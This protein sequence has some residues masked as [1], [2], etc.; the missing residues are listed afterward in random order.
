MINLLTKKKLFRLNKTHVL[1]VLFLISINSFSQFLNSSFEDNTTNIA[2][3]TPNTNNSIWSDQNLTEII[4]NN[5]KNNVP[6]IDQPYVSNRLNE[7]GLPYLAKS[8]NSEKT[9]K[10][11]ITNIAMVDTDNDGVDDV[12]DIDDD[13][14]GILDVN[15]CP[16]TEKIIYTYTGTDQ[17]YTVPSNATSVTAKIWGAGGRG[18][19]R[20]G[21]GVGAA[22]GYTEFTIS[23]NDITNNTLILTVGEGGNSSTGSPTYGNGGAGSSA[24]FNRA[25]RNFGA[26]GGMS[27]ISYTTL[28]TPSS[29]TQADLLAIAGGGGSMPAYSNANTHAGEGGG[30][31]GGDAT[32]NLATLNGL[33]G[34]QTAGGASTNGNAGSFLQGGNSRVNGAAGGGGYYGGGGGSFLNNH[35]G[36]GGG[37]SS[38]ITSLATAY[39]TIRG[40][41]QLPPMSGDS[42][43]IS[44]VGTGGSTSAQNGG[45]GLIV[46][47]ITLE[48]DEDGDGIINSFD[49]DSDN[50]GIPDNLE[51]QSTV[52][53]IVPSGNDIDKDGLDDTYDA[54]LSGSEN[55]LGITPV[56]TDD[57]ANIGADTLP[58][59]LD[60]DADGDG[61]FD[62]IESGTVL[63]NDGNGVSTGTFGI[64]G[65]NDLAETGNTDLGYTD[66]NGSFDNTQTDNFTDIDEDVLTFGDVDYRD[67]SDD[68]IAMITQVYQF[69]DERW[70]E[71]TNINKTKSIAANL[72][73]IQLYVDRTGTQ[74]TAPNAFYTFPNILAAGKSILLKS[75]NNT[76]TN[77]DNSD[78][79]RVITNDVITNFAG[80]NDMV[81]LSSANDDSSYQNRYDIIEAF[82]DKTSHVRIDETLI[83]NKDYDAAEWVVFIDDAILP[84]QTV[85][86]TAITGV[87]RHPQDPLISEIT[88]SNTAANT[89]LGLHNIDITT[90][91]S[92][93]NTWTN[94]YPDRSRSVVIDQDFEHT[95]NRLSARK[96]KVNA[97]QELTVT[98]QLLVVTN[99]ITL[100]GDIRLAGT[101]A[102]LVQTHTTGTK[103]SGNGSLLVDQNSEIPS[104]YRYGY[105]SSPVNSSGTTYTVEDV[106]KDGT[107]PT[108]PKDITFVS[109]FDGSFT[110]TGIS[111]ADYWIYTYAPAS[112]GRANWVQQFK[113]GVINRA[114]GYIFKG[115]GRAQNYTFIGTPNDGGF[116]TALPIG[117]GDDYLVGNPFP[118]AMNARK[119]IEDNLATTTGT[120]YLWEH[121]ESANGEGN[122][123]DGHVFGGY[124]GG[125]ATI[126]LGGTAAASSNV[127]DNN[128][129]GTSG[130]GDASYS[131]TSPLPYIAIG[132]G[133]FIE[134]DETTGGIVNFNNSQRAY[135]TEGPESVFFKANKKT[136]TTTT[137]LLPLIKLGFEYKNTDE[138]NIHHQI[139]VTFQETNSFAFNK[140]YDSEVYETG[141]TDMYWKFP[142][143]DK[144]YV[145]AGVQEISNELE[146]PLEVIVDYS[147]QVNIMVDETENV[148]RDIYI[149]DK[150]TGTSYNVTDEKIT[151]TL[152]KGIYTDRFVLAFSESNVLG[153][154]D[155]DVLSAFTNIYADNENHQIVISKN[156]EVEINKVE[157]FDILGKKV[158]TWKIKEQKDTYQ[159]EIKKQIPTGIYIVKMNTDKGIINKKIMI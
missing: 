89:L 118:S 57:T 73:Q 114:D 111:L 142:N 92:A 120:L 149:T 104:L 34:T 12:T 62:V 159:L 33:G 115:P 109:G 84:Y 100:D 42:D 94:G 123:I 31:T 41:I 18:D 86:N 108:T 1:W 91:N 67:I 51:A 139:T 143:D 49:L 69:D 48:C 148:T 60:L 28:N 70:I 44:G 128:D 36:G 134:G 39:Q 156:N 117:A 110:S 122:G 23:K 141:K 3:T 55:S 155:D 87:K 61:I 5:K 106:L 136:N 35:E 30:A 79:T 58:D 14:D 21:R 119:F 88:T 83:Y 105:M 50:D 102:Q 85:G 8:I 98:D 135:V 82:A 19:E 4:S 25:L 151:L 116:D 112:N 97:N 93:S 95:G 24:I 75:T 145:I 101:L 113:N 10:Y 46:L 77:F 132:Q 9:S 150:L 72:I 124:V 129:N 126:N 11:R 37:G 76:I 56:N 158:N 43:Y 127:P 81:T 13:N 154:D 140:G 45:N 64:N 121:K 65:L 53:Y 153:L 29:V 96:L 138:L 146:V 80:A 54:N 66:V 22:G 131:Y 103:I 40:N 152:D 63:P 71:V 52:D 15:E 16:T 2:F 147:G 68:G 32:D 133:F 90:S 144:K 99:D 27:A 107:D 59:Y 125:Y 78:P 7:T 47:I 137:D 26:G 157:L 20:P 6:F 38:Y 130:T 17:T 74:S